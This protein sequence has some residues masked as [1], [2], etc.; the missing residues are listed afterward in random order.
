MHTVPASSLEYTVQ[1]S[2]RCS[3]TVSPMKGALMSTDNEERGAQCAM[4]ATRER[5]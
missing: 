4:P 2:R 1:L 5:R 3:P